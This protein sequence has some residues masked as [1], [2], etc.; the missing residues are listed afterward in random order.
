[1]SQLWMA[2]TCRGGA[3]A[4]SG[5]LRGRGHGITGPEWT[6]LTRMDLDLT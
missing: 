2:G 5:N 6:Y 3:L 4:I 1:M